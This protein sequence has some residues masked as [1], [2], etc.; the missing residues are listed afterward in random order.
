M[1]DDTN[2]APKPPPLPGAPSTWARLRAAPVTTAIG[3]AAAAATFAWWTTGRV[4]AQDRD[5]F[6]RLFWRT[7]EETWSGAWW[8]LVTSSLLHVN[9]AHVALNLYWMY[10]LVT[11][12]ERRMGPLRW[13]VFFVVTTAL[14]S[15]AELVIGNAPGMGLSGF[16]YAAFGF[17][18]RRSHTDPRWRGVVHRAYPP[19]WIGWGVLCWVLTAAHVMQVGNAAHAAGLAAGLGWAFVTESRWWYGVRITAAAAV[20]GGATAGAVVGVPWS[21]SWHYARAM[22]AFRVPDAAAAVPEFRRAKELGFYAGSCLDGIAAMEILRRNR[23]GYEEAMKEFDALDAKASRAAR[24]RREGSAGWEVMCA[25][26]EMDARNA[27][28]ALPHLF[29]AR[30]L[31][32]DRKWCLESIAWAHCVLRDSAEYDATMA[33]LKSVDAAAWEDAR[34]RYGASV[35]K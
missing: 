19:L 25:M 23:T 4:T 11:E 13:L 26:E 30:D 12:C 5:A 33:E 34:S 27:K 18:W 10:R 21:G 29:R 6:C 32:V 24:A 7:P 8:T 15:F 28:A 35:P 16:E 20:L 2:D 31:G 14:A 17:A 3:V 1:A 9:E 22:E